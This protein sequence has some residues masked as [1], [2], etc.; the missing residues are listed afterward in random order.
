MKKILPK[1]GVFVII[2]ILAGV[3]YVIMTHDRHQ[4]GESSNAPARSPNISSDVAETLPKP[5]APTD[6]SKSTA[7]LTETLS[8]K[9]LK[10]LLKQFYSYRQNPNSDAVLTLSSFLDHTNL[11]HT[12][13]I[14]VLEAIDTLTHIALENDDQRETVFKILQAKAADES[15]EQRDKALF[16]AAMLGKDRM[17]PIVANFINNPDE[18]SPVESYDVASRA[19]A[20]IRSWWISERSWCF[21]QSSWRLR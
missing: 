6:S 1:I 21:W 4:A 12:D 8:N 9:D 20:T 14:V 18:H 7:S 3:G 13:R 2:T 16:M 5:P 11:D 10:E 19:L 15:F 17:L